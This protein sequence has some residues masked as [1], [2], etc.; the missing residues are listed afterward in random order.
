MWKFRQVTSRG[1][2]VGINSSDKSDLKFK[3]QLENEIQMMKDLKHPRIVTYFGHDYMD[4][5][6]IGWAELMMFF[7]LMS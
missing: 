7:P 2:E 5:A 3:E 6:W 4:D 1:Q